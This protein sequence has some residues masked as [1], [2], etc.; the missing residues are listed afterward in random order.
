MADDKEDLALVD[1]LQVDETK[2]IV[3]AELIV[4]EPTKVLSAKHVESQSSMSSNALTLRVKF[5]K[6]KR[7]SIGI[8]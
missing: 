3:K 8:R 2:I 5:A 1:P 7:P 6:P 4:V